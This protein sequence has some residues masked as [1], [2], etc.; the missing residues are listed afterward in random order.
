MKAQ[1]PLP[2]GYFWLSDGGNTECVDGSCI[3][4]QRWGIGSTTSQIE[5]DFIMTVREFESE[6]ECFEN[7]DLQISF[8]TFS[9]GGAGCWEDPVGECLIDRKQLGPQWIIEC[10]QT[11]AIIA[12]PQPRDICTEDVVDIN[13]YTEDGSS[14]DIVVTFEDNPNVDGENEHTFSNGSGTID[15]IL[16]LNND[17]CSPEEVIYYAEAIDPTIKCSGR[18]D[19][20]IVT[21]YPNPSLDQSFVPGNCYPNLDLYDLNDYLD[22]TGYP[23]ELNWQWAHSTGTPTGNTSFIQF[24]E[25]FE[26]GTHVFS[27]TVTDE[28]GCNAIEEISIDVYPPVH[29]IMEDMTLCYDDEP[30]Y[31]CPDFDEPGT[32]QYDY[33]WVFDCLGQ[34]DNSDCFFIEPAV[35]LENCGED[36]NEWVLD[37]LVLDENYCTFDTSITITI[38]PEPGFNIDPLNPAFCEG[39]NEVEVCLELWDDT[40]I[41]QAEW[42]LAQGGTVITYEPDYCVTL[43]WEGVYY[44]YVTDIYGCVIEYEF[45]VGQNTIDEFEIAGDTLICIGE[46]TT[47]SVVGNYDLYN[48]STTET[49]QSITVTPAVTT[50]YSVNVIDANG[51]TATNDVT[52]HVLSTELPALPDT[53]SFCTGFSTLINAGAGYDQYTWYFGSSTGTVIGTSDT[54]V[55]DQEGTY[56]IE[57]LLQGCPA[58]DS[59]YVKE[60]NELTPSV[61]GD[62]LLCFEQTNTLIIATGG[63]F[64]EYIWT[65]IGNVPNT[66]VDQGTSLDSI[67]LPEG[68]YELYVSDGSCSGTKQFTINKKPPVIVDIFPSVDT[69][70]ICYNTDTMIYATPGFDSYEWNTGIFNDTLFNVGKGHY[71]V[72]V[73]DADGCIGVDSIFIKAFPPVTP[74]LGPTREICADET[75]ILTPGSGFSTYIWYFD[76]VHNPAWDGQESIEVNEGGEYSVDVTNAIGCFGT[77]LVLVEKTDQLNPTIIGN[78]AICQGDVLTLSVDQPYFSYSWTNEAGTQV[79]T[80]QTLDVTI[81]GTYTVEV[82]SQTGCLGTDQ[83]T[84]VVNI[85]P[86]AN[87]DNDPKNACG[88]NSS[89]GSTILDFSSYVDP[90]SDPGVWT[91]TDGSGV[92]TNGDWSQVDFSNVAA[93]TYTYTFTNTGA[94]APC[95]NDSDV[96]TVIVTECDCYLF[97]ID[98]IDDLCNEGSSAINLDD[99]LVST[100]SGLSMVGTWTVTDGPGG[101]P[102]SGNMFDP[103]GAA[104][105]TYTLTFTFTDIGE[106][107][108]E[109]ADVTVVVARAPVIGIVSD[110]P[111]ECF[112]TEGLFELESLITGEDAGGTWTEITS[113]TGSA[114]DSVTGT[115]NTLDQAVGTYTFEYTLT[116]VAPCIDKSIQVSVAISEKPIADAGTPGFAC[117]GDN[118]L[119]GGSSSNG[120]VYTYEWTNASGQVVSTERTF[121]TSTAGTYTLVV[122][123]SSTGCNDTDATSVVIFPDYSGEITGKLILTDGDTD[124][125]RLNLTG[126][127]KS[128]VGSY[129]WTKDG[130]LIPGANADT[131]FVEETGIYCVLITP[132]GAD[133]SACTLEVCKDVSTTLN[134]EVYIPNVFSPNGDGENDIFT[135][136]GGKNVQQILS[137]SVYDR[138]GELVFQSPNPFQFDKK[139]ENGWDGQFKGQRAMQGVYVY[140][141]EVLYNDD[142]GET[143]GGDITLIR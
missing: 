69:I 32:P 63:A 76:G 137:I 88:A 84:V 21:V 57:V 56:Y 46:S 116:A 60:D 24:N 16:I 115:F 25:S 121:E 101:N 139:Y 106:F 89:N 66:I 123:D 18:Q 97:S 135:I 41:E 130:S 27:V 81:A 141:V 83:V 90:T 134:K 91:D 58:L 6:E 118:V 38:N 26:G 122:T 131:L 98:P 55:V 100:P 17:W 105:G 8:Q 42:Y 87:V 67:Y 82:A 128:Q 49:T 113:S 19:T 36:A 53:A 23:G 117:F 129:T 54:I 12:T 95:V 79:G 109:S 9:D 103:T 140:V 136:E 51:C 44:V 43:T 80:S 125:L 1:E 22:C 47:L 99:L 40:E 119:V 15:D 68:T 31:L 33:N 5:W 65:D 64:I 28:L 120:T 20:I 132:A 126:L 2:S 73:T 143:I 133:E 112:G 48:W 104:E 59:I 61:Y 71:E 138:W 85:P 62:M 111:S 37:L 107:C 34:L 4:A 94:I 35:I 72:T 102:I 142:T 70:Y 11:P 124:V 75:A 77:D 29:F 14:L 3:S 127:D 50:T 93:G 10:D 110:S 114:F 96:L 30:F 108:E 13:V 52:V 74:N 78:A 39:A 7:N 45:E 92:I 86:N